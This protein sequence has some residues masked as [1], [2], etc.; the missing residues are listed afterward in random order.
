MRF[1]VIGAGAVG[2]VVGG[3]LVRSGHDVAFV[4]RG[5]HGAHIAAHGLTVQTPTGE[6]TVDVPAAP[7]VAELG[8][9]SDDIVLLAV[10]SND[11]AGVLADLAAAAPRSTPVVC[12]Q[13]GVANEALAAEHFDRVYGV[14]VMCPTLHLEPGVVVAYASPV[15][16]ILDI[17]RYPGGTDDTAVAVADAFESSTIVSEVR[18][19]IMRW[20]WAKLLLNLGNAIEAVCGQEARFSA[21]GQMVRAE[22]EAV[23]NAAG[24]DFVTAEQDAARR[25]DILRWSL[26]DRPGGSSWQSLARGQPI[27]TDYLNGEIVRLGAA[28]GVAT[29]V[30][31][32]LTRRA[33]E[34][35]VS[36][37]GPGRVPVE[38]ILAE[39][40]AAP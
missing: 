32:V 21:L 26:K 24:I 17:G 19:D 30:N 39:T 23:L 37:T 27:E 9:T 20:K 10:K 28:H 35:A 1:V 18:P 22:G 3:L 31:A 13:N 15:A 38:E 8:M 5:A 16:A 34:L 25:G 14:P 6:F 4:A 2:G 33:N 11:T 36:G 7:A 29:P 12:L 40:A